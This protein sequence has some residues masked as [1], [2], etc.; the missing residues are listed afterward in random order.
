MNLN[1]VAVYADRSVSVEIPDI[2][3][4]ELAHGRTT[5]RFASIRDAS[6]YFSR[7]IYKAKRASKGKT[8]EKLPG[9]AK[10]DANNMPIHTPQGK[11][12]MESKVK[13]YKTFMQS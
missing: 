1:I 13:H 8:L 11:L 7:L 10:L 5:M 6:R 9:T 2:L 4:A 12:R 3:K